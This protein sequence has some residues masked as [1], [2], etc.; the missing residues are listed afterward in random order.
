MQKM[1]AIDEFGLFNLNDYLP[2]KPDAEHLEVIQK[3]FEASLDGEPYDPARFSNYYR[4]YGIDFS[5]TGDASRREQSQNNDAPVKEDAK[6]VDS[7]K[8]EEKVTEPAKASGS[9]SAQELL[10]KLR[11]NQS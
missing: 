11:N 10:A 5:N 3:M 4:P 6:E 8:S 9:K 1:K 7:G 2:N